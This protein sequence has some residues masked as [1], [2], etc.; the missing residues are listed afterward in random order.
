V[1][2]HA[3]HGAGSLI[4]RGEAAEWAAKACESG[5]DDHEDSERDGA[6]SAA[7]GQSTLVGPKTVDLPAV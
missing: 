7:D 4:E 1:I 2:P 6:P 3:A 5:I